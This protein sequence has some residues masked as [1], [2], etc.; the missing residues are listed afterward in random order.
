M[1]YRDGLTALR[2]RRAEGVPLDRREI[3]LRFATLRGGSFDD[4]DLFVAFADVFNAV[5][6]PAHITFVPQRDRCR[7][8]FDKKQLQ[9]SGEL[10]SAAGDVIGVIE[11][12]LDFEVGIA[13]HSRII[14]NKRFRDVGIAAILL[15]HSLRFYQAVE[16]PEVQLT[17]ALTT[18]PYYWAK[19]GFQFADAAD[20]A[21]VQHWFARVN[22]KLALGLDCVSE[23]PPR[24]WLL[25]GADDGCTCTLGMIASAFPSERASIETRAKDNR[26]GLDEQIPVGKA[27]LLS[28]PKWRGRL[29]AT[30]RSISF[31]QTYVR[32]RLDRAAV[33]LRTPAEKNPSEPDE[34]LD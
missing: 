31:V 1:S 17:A 24:D 32:A 3:E 4:P 25:I 30:R 20:S 23:R 12:I 14:V 13:W 6:A 9:F 28:G 21:A 5:C 22:A 8:D 19:L 10:R 7:I 2:R 11:R 27:I 29:P 33:L 34:P 15:E 16:L 26:I 18:G